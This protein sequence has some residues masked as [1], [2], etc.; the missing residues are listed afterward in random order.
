MR[1]FIIC[2]LHQVLLVQFTVLWVVILCNVVVEY[3]CSRDPCCLHLEGE[4]NG[5]G[6]KI[7]IDTGLE[8]VMVTDAT[9]Q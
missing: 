3:Q 1:S 2:T 6:E 8:C 5:D 7:G 4:G 9:S